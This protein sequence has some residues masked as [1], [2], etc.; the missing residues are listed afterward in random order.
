MRRSQT[1]T[2]GDQSDLA[3]KCILNDKGRHFTDKTNNCRI[4]TFKKFTDIGWE[5]HVFED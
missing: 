3:M 2:W 5:F 4:E 1:N